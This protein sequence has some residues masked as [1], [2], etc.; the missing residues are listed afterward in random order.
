MDVFSAYAQD[1]EGNVLPGAVA[2]VYNRGTFIL[3]TDL[4][5]IDG[6]PIPNPVTAGTDGL[7][8]FSAPIGYYDVRVVAGNRS[9][10]LPASIVDV[11]LQLTQAAGYAS[12]AAS[13]ASS[14]AASASAALTA[15][16]V[17]A[18]TSAGIAGTVNGQFFSIVSSATDYVFDLYQNVSGV[19]TFFTSYTLK[20]GQW[21]KDFI[22]DYTY[23]DLLSIY[24]TCVFGVSYVVASLGTTSQARAID[25]GVDFQPMPIYGITVAAEPGTATQLKVSI[26]SRQTTASN[27]N[28]ASTTT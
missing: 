4:T 3:A 7:I 6:N 9:Y 24:G 1:A 14:A 25:C 2:T 22:T 28:T 20:S 23:R 5:D 11:Q 17:F 12:A 13:S 19:A 10:T 8:Q 21:V 27:V 16:K 15:G 26:Y 18:T